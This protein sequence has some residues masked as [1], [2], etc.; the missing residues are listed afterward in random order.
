[1]TCWSLH[2]DVEGNALRQ[3][4]ILFTQMSHQ[5]F[6]GVRHSL[7][8]CCFKTYQ[9][10]SEDGQIIVRSSFVYLQLAANKFS[11]VKNKLCF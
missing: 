4:K 7:P 8:Y 5:E 10:E 9:Y 1:M 3:K 11:Q 2:M 6:L